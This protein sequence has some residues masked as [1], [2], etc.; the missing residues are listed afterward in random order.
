MTK[1][2]TKRYIMVVGDYFSKWKEAFTLENR[3]AQTVSDKLVTE[4]I[5][6]FGVPYRI[7]TDQGK[8]FES[9]LF[10][11]MCFLLGIMKSRTTPYRPQFDGMVERFNRILQQMLSIFVDENR[12]TGTIICHI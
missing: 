4:V 3:T 9:A 6:R 11:G 5:C 8:E 2:G 1:E 12:L 7:H 10:A